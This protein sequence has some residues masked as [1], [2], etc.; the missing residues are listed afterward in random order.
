MEAFATRSYK[1]IAPPVLVCFI[2]LS[3]A[4]QQ[5]QPA[6]QDFS[7]A[8][9]Y[10]G[11]HALPRISS[12]SAAWQFRTRIR[13]AAKH[14]PNFAGHYVLAAW[15]CG[16]ECLRYAVI[17]VVSGQVYFNNETNMSWWGAT[18]PDHFVPLDFRSSSRLLVLTGALGGE[19]RNT[20]H[21]FILR[22]GRLT[23]LR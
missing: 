3:A 2:G 19:G 12:G 22:R 11:P 16:S 17:D 15:G 20:T 18:L 9:V 21:Y 1:H 5:Q 14:P 13:E 7:V 10:K 8:K 23:P 6:F 4:G